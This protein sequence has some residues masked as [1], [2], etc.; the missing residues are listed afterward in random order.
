MRWLPRVEGHGEPMMAQIET[1]EQFR[2]AIL[3]ERRAD[4]ATAAAFVRA[5]RFTILDALPHHN[6][7]LRSP[8]A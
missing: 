4:R 6:V 3:A 8:F 5:C 2:A 7:Y 1:I